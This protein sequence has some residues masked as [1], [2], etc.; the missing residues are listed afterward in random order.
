MTEESRQA[1]SEVSKQINVGAKS[2]GGGG[3]GRGK[4]QQKRRARLLFSQA[5]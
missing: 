2:K 3:N 1:T 4:K 5:L